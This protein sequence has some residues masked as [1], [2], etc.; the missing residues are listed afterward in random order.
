M[1]FYLQDMIKLPLEVVLDMKRGMLSVQRTEGKF[2]AVNPDLAL[3]QFRNR[4][5]AVTG[6]LIGK[7]E[8]AM[9]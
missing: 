9:Q 4:S 7:N 6:G 2:S 8:E 5:S 1:T 3:E